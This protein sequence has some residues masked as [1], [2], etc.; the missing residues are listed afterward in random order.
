MFE[1]WLFFNCMLEW[2]NFVYCFERDAQKTHL[3]W[4]EHLRKRKLRQTN[5][6]PN[7]HHHNY[8]NE[9][10]QG[11]QT[12]GI[13][14]LFFFWK[15]QTNQKCHNAYIMYNERAPGTSLHYFMIIHS[16]LLKTFGCEWKTVFAVIDLCTDLNILMYMLNI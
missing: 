4:R 12:W 1:P 14:I 11:E 15:K 5:Q 13:Q 10:Q 8:S 3:I 2:A 7:E 16:I 9:W 6:T